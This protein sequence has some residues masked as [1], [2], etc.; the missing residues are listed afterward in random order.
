MKSLP[1]TPVIECPPSSAFS[2]SPSRLY[3]GQYRLPAS[4]SFSAV[5]THKPASS[6]TAAREGSLPSATRRRYTATSFSTDASRRRA[7][8][9][10]PPTAFASASVSP[11]VCAAQTPSSSSSPTFPRRNVPRHTERPSSRSPWP[12]SPRRR[13]HPR[14]RRHGS[15]P[16]AR[17]RRGCPPPRRRD[18][19]SRRWRRPAADGRGCSIPRSLPHCPSLP[20]RRSSKGPSTG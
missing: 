12:A 7:A 15:R 1:G 2:R 11:L 13:M 14:S 18:G 5:R 6:A 3:L 9:Y 16:P 4:N 19:G 10:R 17:T 8:A 20:P